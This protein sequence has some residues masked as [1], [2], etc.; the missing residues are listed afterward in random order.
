MFHLFHK[1]EVVDVIVQP[2]QWSH[3]VYSTGTKIPYTRTNY[4]VKYKCKLCDKTKF[5]SF[6]GDD[7]FIEKD[8]ALVTFWLKENKKD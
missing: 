4:T 7:S 5:N 2:E 8:L 1:F 6:Y 3:L